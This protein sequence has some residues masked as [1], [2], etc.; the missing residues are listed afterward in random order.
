[1]GGLEQALVLVLA[2]DLEQVVAETLEEGERD[3]RVVDERPVPSR[4]RELAA[5]E[6]LA[7]LDLRRAELVVL[8][9]CD[10]RAGLR[11]AG[12]ALQSLETALAIAGAHSSITSLWAVD[13]DAARTLMAEFYRCLFVLREA[14]ATALWDAKRT[15]RSRGAPL[16]D[17]AGWTLS[18]NAGAL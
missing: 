17:W 9:A 10:T 15:L 3:G 16:S 14:R 2:V 13:D 12:Q 11:R 8:S 1:M 7:G 18:G 5:D 4:A 6:E